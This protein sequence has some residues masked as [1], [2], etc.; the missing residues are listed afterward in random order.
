M[1]DSRTTQATKSRKMTKLPDFLSLSAPSGS[2]SQIIVPDNVLLFTLTM[3]KQKFGQTRHSSKK[4][5]DLS[6][7]VVS[8]GL[9]V[10]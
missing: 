3:M 5:C 1:E 2:A 9:N 10:I 6:V 7:M 4:V 8:V